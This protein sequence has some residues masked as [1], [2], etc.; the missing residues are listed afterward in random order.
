LLKLASPAMCRALVLRSPLVSVEAMAEVAA[1]VD[2]AELWRAAFA[3][4]EGDLRWLVRAARAA[5]LDGEEADEAEDAIRA[6]VGDSELSRLRGLQFRESCAAALATLL[7]AAGRRST[8]IDE[9]AEGDR[10][11]RPRLA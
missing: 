4:V 3:E 8:V 9:W 1:E 6:P 5:G 2:L 7:C 10:R 11:V